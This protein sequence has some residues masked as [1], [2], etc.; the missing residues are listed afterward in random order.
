MYEKILFKKNK[1]AKVHQLIIIKLIFSL[2]ASAFCKLLLIFNHT[3][4]MLSCRIKYLLC[5]YILATNFW[6]YCK[7]VTQLFYLFFIIFGIIITNKFVK[8]SYS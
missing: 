6:L 5:F 3:E 1:P 8:K 4:T 2:Q 7:I